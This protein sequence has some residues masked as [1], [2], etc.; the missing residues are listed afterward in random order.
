M[1]AAASV[2]TVD[3]AAQAVALIAQV[4]REEGVEADGPVDY[5]AARTA[6]TILKARERHLKILQ[7]RRELVPLALQQKHTGD[8]IV[9][10]RQIWQRMPSRHGAAMAA[11]LGVSAAELDRVL[12]RA[13][14]ADLDEM[15]KVAIKGPT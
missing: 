14:A 6:E 13:I 2:R 7:R 11:E 4:L 15:S 1:N 8:A 10:L 5:N 12:T 3:D 9:A